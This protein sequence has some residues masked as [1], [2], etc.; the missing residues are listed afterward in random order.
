MEAERADES[1]KEVDAFFEEED[2]AWA[3]LFDYLKEKHDVDDGGE[4]KEYLNLA[5]QGKNERWRYLIGALM[6][7]FSYILLV[8]FVNFLFF[9]LKINKLFFID[10]IYFLHLLFVIQGLIPIMGI[11]LTVHFLHKRSFKS[12]IT[13]KESINFKRI[14]FGFTV[15]ILLYLIYTI[16]CYFSDPSNFYIVFDPIKFFPFIPIALISIFLCVTSEE[17]IFR[18]YLIQGLGNWIKNI[19]VLSFISGMLFAAFHLTPSLLYIIFIFIMGFFLSIITLKDRTIELAI[20]VH[21]ANNL[22]VFLFVNSEGDI[23]SYSIFT[24]SVEDPF[25]YIFSFIAMALIFYFFV[26]IVFDKSELKK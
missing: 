19:W 20:G 12:L 3:E 1:L 25:I 14:L 26:F 18:S 22:F 2:E 17:L 8:F 23:P 5:K 21:A 11:F 7:V 15:F 10:D 13:Y 9:N 6:I 24:R 16:I 4:S